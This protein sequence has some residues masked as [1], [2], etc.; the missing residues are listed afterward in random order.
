MLLLKA[1]AVFSRLLLTEEEA[2]VLCEMLLTFMKRRTEGQGGQG[3][4]SPLLDLAK[5]FYSQELF[6]TY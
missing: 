2:G 4:V 1:A 3:A 6:N 5:T